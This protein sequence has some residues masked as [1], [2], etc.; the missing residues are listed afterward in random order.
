MKVQSPYFAELFS[1]FVHWLLSIGPQ[2][3]I[4][5]T[6]YRLVSDTK[7]SATPHELVNGRLCIVITFETNTSEQFCL[8]DRAMRLW[9][10]FDF[11]DKLGQSMLFFIF[12]NISRSTHAKQLSLSLPPSFF[13]S[14]KPSCLPQSFVLSPSVPACSCSGLVPVSSVA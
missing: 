6:V 13:F 1:V 12:V 14:C 11:S 2:H 10:Q 7:K 3:S 5:M 9:K 4:N 8:L